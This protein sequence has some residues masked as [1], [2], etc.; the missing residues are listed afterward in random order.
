MYLIHCTTSR[1]RVTVHF[2]KSALNDPKMSLNTTSSN[3][4]H[5]CYLCHW[6]PNFTPFCS[7]ASCFWYIGHFGTS[8]SNDPKM[9]L[10][11]TRL[12]VPNICTTTVPESQISL[13]FP[14]RPA[15][16]EIQAILRQVHWITP[17][18]PWTL[19]SQITLYMY[20]W[21][22]RFPNFTPFRCK[23]SHLQD[24]GNFETSALN[25]PKMAL[26]PTRSKVPHICVTSVHE[27]Q[28]SLH[29]TVQP[30]LRYRPFWDRGREWPQNDLE[31]YKVI[32]CPIYVLL[33]NHVNQYYLYMGRTVGD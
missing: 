28:I 15:L 22:P 25:D 10:N 21:C 3:V 11:P 9:T 8:A 31:R 16:F 2:E 23:A 19:K 27:S 5:M 20:N 17:K 14:L 26:N 4:P 32:M 13:S 29:F 1:F 24:T 12:N 7:T 6:F 30:A 33:V 18:W